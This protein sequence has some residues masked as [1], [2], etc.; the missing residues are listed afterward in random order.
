MK[1]AKKLGVATTLLLGFSWTASAEIV[2]VVGDDIEALWV[3]I[4]CL[5]VA[6]VVG[7]VILGVAVVMGCRI[8]A[9]PRKDDGSPHKPSSVSEREDGAAP[10]DRSD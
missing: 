10:E 5:A 4:F 8:L 9:R 7:S 3:S 2:N 6:V 1:S